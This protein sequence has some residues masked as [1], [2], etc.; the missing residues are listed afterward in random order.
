MEP[1]SEKN[2]KEPEKP[3]EDFV[4]TIDDSYKRKE[5]LTTTVDNCVT[6]EIVQGDPEVLFAY[7][8]VP[9]DDLQSLVSYRLLQSKCSKLTYSILI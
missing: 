8:V 5:V 7:V 9:I 2:K 1:I 6:F 3:Y 4:F